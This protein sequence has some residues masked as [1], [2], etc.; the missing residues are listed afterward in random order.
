M[1]NPLVPISGATPALTDALTRAS[2]YAQSSKADATRRAYSSDWHHFTDWCAARGVTP[3]PASVETAAAY[4]AE[5]ADSG[6]KVSTIMRRA[7]ALSYAHRLAGCPSPCASEPTK[8][9][10]RGIRRR[11]GVAVA[12]KSPATLRAISAMV[13]RIPSTVIGH[14]DRAILLLGFAAALR[15]SELVDLKVNDLEFSAEGLIVHIRRS[16]TDQEGAGHQVAVP[17]GSQL[18]PVEAVEAWLRESQLTE[19]PLFRAVTAKGRAS[20]G[21][22]TD[23]TVA[24]IVKRY[25]TAA[26]LNPAHYAGHSLRSGFVTSALEHGADVLKVMDVTRHKHVQTLKGYDRRAKAFRDHAGS[27]FL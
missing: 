2:G 21:A 11:V 23:R 12:Q 10:L 6:R 16:K 14:R 18:R 24:R 22:L 4:L 9:V 5:L 15:R 1:D 3:L 17:R 20:A 25:A 8:A 19:G 13:E 7:A 26:G 27:K